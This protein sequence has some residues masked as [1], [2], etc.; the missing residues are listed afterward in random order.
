MTTPLTPG[1][2]RTFDRVVPILKPGTHSLTLE[3]TVADADTTLVRVAAAPVTLE[4]SDPTAAAL[5]PEVLAV[6]PP[7][8][9]EDAADTMLPHVALRARSLPWARGTGQTWLAVLLFTR[10]EL[11]KVNGVEPF[12][13]SGAHETLTCTRTLFDA[14]VPRPA[15]RELLCHVRE[16]P[17]DDPL[18]AA[19]DDRFVAIVI[20]NRIPRPGLEHIACLVD[21]GDTGVGATATLRV[22]HRWGFKT[23][24]GGDFE[25]HFRRLREP[26]TNPT[27]GVRAI[28]Q[29]TDGT[30][31]GDPDGALS[32]AAPTADQPDRRVL[33]AGPLAPLARAYRD[34]PIASVDAALAVDG[35]GT[36]VVG[37]AAAFELGALL[38]RANPRILDALLA[39]RGRQISRDL[40]V[41]QYAPNPGLTPGQIDFRGDWREVFVNTDDWWGTTDDN[42]WQ[43]TGDPTGLLAL[44]GQIP[45]LSQDR[46]QG[47]GGTQIGA[48]LKDVGGATFAS[49]GPGATVTI[50]DLVGLDLGTIAAPDL[51]AHLHARFSGLTAAVAAITLDLAEEA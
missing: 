15:E 39:F 16:L 12:T 7:A 32:L 23:A 5:A 22:V 51:G 11:P 37:E 1:Y 14:L 9:S 3:Q 8:G 48:R 27:G 31:L 38:A 34:E 36:D 50:P 6:Y 13:P 49:D 25:A 10:D 43:R 33:Y 35:D 17:T 26:G 40:E 24:A 2:L 30:A 41:P 47:L 19:D 45:G 28:G 44:V 46:L 21:L 20:G 18:S 29:R 4:I 42:L